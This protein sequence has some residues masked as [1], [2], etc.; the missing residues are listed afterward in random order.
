VGFSNWVH[1]DVAEVLVETD[2]AFR[3]SL[4]DGLEFWLP[5]SQVSEAGKYE[6]GDTDCTISITQWLADKLGVE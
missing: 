2:D 5:K 4:E 1:L 3:V 6:Q